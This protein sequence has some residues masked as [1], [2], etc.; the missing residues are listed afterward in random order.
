VGPLLLEPVLV[1]VVAATEGCNQSPLLLVLPILA[2]VA[3]AVDTTT[4]ALLVVPV[5]S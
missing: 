5:S 3:A 1:L 4:Q 2:A